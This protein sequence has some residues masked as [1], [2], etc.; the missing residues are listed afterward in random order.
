M[1]AQSCDFGLMGCMMKKVKKLFLNILILTA[2]SLLIRTVSVSFSAYL[3]N[4]IGA[5]AIGTYGLI[6]S[7]YGFAM[8]VATSGIKFTVTRLTSEELGKQNEQGMKTIVRKGLCYALGFSIVTAVALFFGAEF[9]AAHWLDNQETVLSLRILAV[10]LPFIAVSHVLSGYFTAIRKVVTGSVIMIID[11]FVMIGITLLALTWLLPKGIAY[12]CLALVLGSVLSEVITCLLLW[13]EYGL[14]GRRRK[15]ST[16][17]RGYPISGVWGRLLAISLPIALS[18]YARSGLYTLQN[19][20]IP[21]GLRKYGATG[22]EALASYGTIHGMVLPM[23]LYP[24]ALLIALSE[25][26]I[27]EL[28]ECQVQQNHRQINYMIHR[29]LKMSFLFAA[30]VMGLLFYFSSDLSRLFEDHPEVSFYLKVFAPLVLVMYMDTV[31]DGMLKGLGEQLNSMKYNVID[32]FVSVL[33]V[34]FLIPIFGIRGYVLTVM[35]S[36]LLNFVLSFSRLIK[37]T[38]IKIHLL[39]IVIKP[40]ICIVGAVVACTILLEESSFTSQFFPAG[41]VLQMGLM[42]LFYGSALFLTSCLK[43]EEL[44]WASGVIR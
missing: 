28:T 39:D 37:I 9:I 17:E 43:R 12:A 35:V 14:E 4:R 42:I 26:L 27:P 44:R 19:L 2:T 5:T 29:V 16:K 41:M 3:F 22:S 32:S 13:M 18:A 34:F 33:L 23:V 40:L 30:C 38:Q 11:Q 31:V 21:K 24:S 10:G 8:T 15:A 25:L 7:V 1:L 36:E 6:L 20:L